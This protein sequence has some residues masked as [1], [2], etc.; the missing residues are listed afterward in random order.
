MRRIGLLL[1]DLHALEVGLNKPDERNF[2]RNT[3]AAEIEGDVEM[4]YVEKRRGDGW[5][6]NLSTSLFSRIRP[7]PAVLIL[8]PLL[9]IHN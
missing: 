3:N 1:R 5:I 6:P 7:G 4:S 9:A 2:L 8:L